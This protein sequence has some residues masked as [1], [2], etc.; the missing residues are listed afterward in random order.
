MSDRKAGLFVRERLFAQPNS[1]HSK[2]HSS[3]GIFFEKSVPNEADGRVVMFFQKKYDSVVLLS[4]MRDPCFI[5]K[6]GGRGYK[7]KT[8]AKKV[9]QMH[10]RWSKF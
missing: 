4:I 6:R 1:Y 7:V 3:H 9:V 8:G 2:K 5:K 10:K